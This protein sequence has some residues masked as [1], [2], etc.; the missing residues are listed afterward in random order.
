MGKE[1]VMGRLNDFF[2]RSQSDRALMSDLDAFCL[3]MQK[4]KD[5]TLAAYVSELTETARK[6]GIF[7]S[8]EDFMFKSG[9][10]ND[11]ELEG[12]SGGA[13]GNCLA[14]LWLDLYDMQPG[15]YE[16]TDE[17]VKSKDS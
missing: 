9:E 10:L 13:G 15:K 6:Y 1:F 8:P 14:Q 2:K 4:K 3:R 11:L 5:K 16:G 17:A 12:V 7:L